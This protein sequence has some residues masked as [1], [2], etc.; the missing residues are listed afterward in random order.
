[1]TKDLFSRRFSR[2]G[3]SGLLAAI[4]ACGACAPAMAATTTTVD[5]SGCAAPAVNQYLM[6]FKDNH[7][8]TYMPGERNDSFD[9]AGW[10][11]SGGASIKTVQLADGQQGTVLD[12]PSGSKAVSPAICVNN[13]YP[14]AR[15][16]V[17]DVVGSQGVFFYVSYEGTSTWSTPKN[18]GQF[19]GQSTDW[20]LSGNINLQPNK[21]SGWQIVRFTFV[22][23][24]TSSDFQV[25][26]FLVDPR[27]RG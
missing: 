11:L 17:R 10:T 13:D 8:Y 23:G 16:H 2:F 4:I 14:T 20:S 25:S 18:T 26:N 9:G 22:P 12:L 3:L 1:M 15:T 7:W 5:T 21:S 27:C 24:G 6:P 19:H